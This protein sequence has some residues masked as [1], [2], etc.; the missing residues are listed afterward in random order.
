MDI[1]SWSSRVGIVASA[2][3]EIKKPDSDPLAGLDNAVLQARFSRI[4]Q[5]A[6]KLISNRRKA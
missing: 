3:P 2:M 4:Y 5:S 1:R 6:R